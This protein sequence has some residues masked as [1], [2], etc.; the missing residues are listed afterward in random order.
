MSARSV[1]LRSGVSTK[2]IT[3]QAL[4]IDLLG[5]RSIGEVMIFLCSDYSVLLLVN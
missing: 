2:A 4:L 5:L 1:R 3:S